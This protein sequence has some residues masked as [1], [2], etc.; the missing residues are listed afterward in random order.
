MKDFLYAQ[1]SDESTYGTGGTASPYTDYQKHLSLK[2][3]GDPA[4]PQDWLIF[5]SATCK[6]YDSASPS[7][8]SKNAVHRLDSLDSS[9]GTIGGTNG[10]AIGL[11]QEYYANYTLTPPDITPISR[12]AAFTYL[13]DFVGSPD[14]TYRE[15]CFGTQ[16]D[17]GDTAGMDIIFRDQKIFAI[18][19]PKNRLNGEVFY[20]NNTSVPNVDTT[21]LP[22]DAFSF[23]PKKG[24]Y[25]IMSMVQYN[26]AYTG[27]AR[28]WA[29]F[30]FKVFQSSDTATE[31]GAAN[32]QI[33]GMPTNSVACTSGFT[34]FQKRVYNNTDVVTRKQPVFHMEVVDLEAEPTTTTWIADCTA[35]S[36]MTFDFVKTVVV[37]LDGN[38]LTAYERNV[39]WK[40]PTSAIGNPEN[41]I[42]AFPFG[43]TGK[44]T[45]LLW[46]TVIQ[47]YGANLI[48]SGVS[49]A[50]A[51][52]LMFGTQNSQNPYNYIDV[53]EHIQT[54]GVHKITG[55]DTV[56]VKFG[57]NGATT[58]G[59]KYSVILAITDP[60]SSQTDTEIELDI[61]LS[62][63]SG[64]LEHKNLMG[65]PTTEAL[66][67]VAT[68]GT[69]LYT[70][71][72]IVEKDT[73]TNNISIAAT[74]TWQ[75]S[76]DGDW[77]DK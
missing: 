30:G 42:A 35:S 51:G 8:T 66:I 57:S 34:Y 53:Q 44:D 56:N 32:L 52:E 24:R 10:E 69:P 21:E 14:N 50:S 15:V 28:Q 55:L 65:L 13:E 73:L 3:P 39:G 71:T 16:K 22:I 18:R 70:N 67:D 64:A 77:E 25:L 12:F 46:N 5:G 68:E 9:T 6:T 7:S 74:D 75:A 37:P 27:A 31:A 19:I 76:V 49:C 62:Q 63:D 43:V 38:F 41:H 23:T 58:T 59:C 33:D 17:S 47:P 60:Q 45:F 40:Y 4:N 72:V 36:R 29:E 2:I 54:A 26:A 1:L 11:S 20:R 61:E 48:Y